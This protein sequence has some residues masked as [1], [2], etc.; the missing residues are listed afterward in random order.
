MDSETASQHPQPFPQLS[1][2][3]LGRRWVDPPFHQTC[4]Q[5]YADTLNEVA[6]SK[7]IRG[8]IKI[9]Y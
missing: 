4:M 5:W 7:E 8:K 3:E 1:P 2:C 6:A 9:S